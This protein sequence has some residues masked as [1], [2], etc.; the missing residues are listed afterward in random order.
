MGGYA[1]AISQACT[2][3]PIAPPAE[4]CYRSIYMRLR[5]GVERGTPGKFFNH[6]KI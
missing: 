2:P 6:L 5:I 4:I 3:P 1:P